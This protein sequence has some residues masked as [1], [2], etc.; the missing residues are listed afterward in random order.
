MTRPQGSI[1]ANGKCYEAGPR[2]NRLHDYK[3]FR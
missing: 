3:F 2:E 1:F